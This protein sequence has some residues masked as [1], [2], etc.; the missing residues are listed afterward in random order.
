[1]PRHVIV[2]RIKF[3][4]SARVETAIT[5]PKHRAAADSDEGDAPRGGIRTVCLGSFACGS[6]FGPAM[7]CGGGA[8]LLMGHIDSTRAPLAPTILR[9]EMRVTPASQNCRHANRIDAIRT[10]AHV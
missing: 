3:L 1:M 8:I 4:R 2:E 7:T 5:S 9:C 10:S 6:G